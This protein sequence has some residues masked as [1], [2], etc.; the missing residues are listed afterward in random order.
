MNYLKT[1]ALMAA[2]M[3]LLVGIG[4]LIGGPGGAMTALVIALAINAVT[5]WFSD[6]II[7]AM[8]RAR[9]VASTEMPQLRALVATVAQAAQIP[10]PKLYVIPQGAPNAFATGRNPQHAAVAV[11]EGILEL[12]NEEELTGVLAH[13]LGHVKNR[14]T[15]IMCVAA[16]IGGAIAMLA[17]MAQWAMMFGGRRD[18]EERNGGAAQLIGLLLIVIL[19]PLAATIIQLAISRS[20]EFGADARGARL[21]GSADGLISALS[22]LDAAAHHQRLETNP[23]TA[24]LFIVNPLHGDVIAALF[25]T[26]PPIEERIRRLRALRV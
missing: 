12:L 11:T 15:L 21:A 16:A 4:Q 1:G 8:Y 5:Y 3:A 25:S 2:L 20:R 13:E 10:M 6:K 14:D 17:N 18:R 26:H 19:A 9:P 7:L 22:K 24:S 23:A